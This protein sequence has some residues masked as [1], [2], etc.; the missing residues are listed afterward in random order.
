MLISHQSIIH[1]E[2]KHK[3]DFVSVIFKHA[4][5]T[6]FKCTGGKSSDTQDYS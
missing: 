5:N 3:T 1:F 4:V 2:T 6:L